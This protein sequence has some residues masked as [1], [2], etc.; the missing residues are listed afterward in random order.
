M[1]WHESNILKIGI[2]LLIC[3]YKTRLLDNVIFL[4][5][6]YLENRQAASQ[7]HNKLQPHHLS[8]QYSIGGQYR[9]MAT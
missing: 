5:Y 8:N 6:L 4:C 1:P 3:N 9:A 2:H 7:I